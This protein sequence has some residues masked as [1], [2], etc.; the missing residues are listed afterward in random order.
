M[1]V[2]EQQQQQ[3]TDELQPAHQI[4]TE[5]VAEQPSTSV[6]PSLEQLQREI[7]ARDAVLQQLAPY[8][9]EIQELF[10]EATPEER[11]FLKQARGIYKEQGSTSGPQ[12]ADEMKP[13]YDKVS[14]LEDFVRKQ[15]QSVEQQRKNEQQEA[16]A[17]DY[18]Y[19]Q[20]LAA[21][22]PDLLEDNGWAI[23]ALKGYADQNRLTLE[24]AWKKVGSRFAK[25][26][27]AAAPPTSLRAD[28]GEIGIPGRS[29]TQ[30]ASSDMSLRDRLLMELR[31]NR[32]AG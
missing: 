28:A 26:S 10:F 30:A 9:Q 18:Q 32:V 24:Q 19:A 17:R 31:K 3:N 20:R 5:S 7:A 21:E 11:A 25:P 22:R 6:E 8:A 16:F 12:I 2:E 15:E 14:Y 29:D 13:L 27:K 23:S 4:G 1:D